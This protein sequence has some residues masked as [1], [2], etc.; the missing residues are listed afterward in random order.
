[1]NIKSNKIVKRIQNV[2]HTYTS[3]QLNHYDRMVFAEP[4]EK[5][6]PT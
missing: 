4:L 6:T 1:M 2:R 3:D 5:K